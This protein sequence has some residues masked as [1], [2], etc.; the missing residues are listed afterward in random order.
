VLGQQEPG[1]VIFILSERGK[2]LLS[3]GIYALECGIGVKALSGDLILDGLPYQ[4]QSVFT[5]L[6]R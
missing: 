5:T 3:P 1:V 4:Q 2:D 6:D